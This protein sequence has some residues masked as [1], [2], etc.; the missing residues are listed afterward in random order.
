MAKKE[1]QTNKQT[2]IACAMTQCIKYIFYQIILIKYT[3]E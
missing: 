1:R 2:D 3:K